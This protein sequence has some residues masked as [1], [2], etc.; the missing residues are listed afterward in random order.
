M[1][2]ALLYLLALPTIII[3]LVYSGLKRQPGIGILLSL[4]IIAYAIWSRPDGL[5]WVG[6]RTQASWPGT[7]GLAVCLALTIALFSTILLEPLV[8]R[9]TGRTHD[10][11]IVEAVRGNSTALVQW[12]VI[13][14]VFV[15]L[16][17]ELIFRGYMMAALTDLLGVSIAALAANLLLSSTV[18]GLAHAYQGP[19]GIVSTGT[20]GVLI[21]LIYLLSGFN[22]WLVI[23]VHGFIDTLQLTFMSANL[24]QRLR[25]LLLPPSGPA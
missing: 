22:L 24:D 18:F 19:S 23:L 7:V 2:P 13:V 9:M 11:S 14:W 3:L 16:L 4:V 1:Q 8:E 12:V 20:V 25:T 10:V 5:A 6:F 21:G 15:A 17:E